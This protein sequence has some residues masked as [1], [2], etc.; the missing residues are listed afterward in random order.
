[1]QLWWQTAGVYNLQYN[2]V[3]QACQGTTMCDLRDLF[4]DQNRFF[5][6]PPLSSKEARETMLYNQP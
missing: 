3:Q 2:V 1:M 5:P 4:F 6:I